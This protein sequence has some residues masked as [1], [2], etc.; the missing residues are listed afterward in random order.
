MMMMMMKKKKR[1]GRQVYW[2]ALWMSCLQ[3]KSGAVAH[4]VRVWL[5]TCLTTQPAALLAEQRQAASG[6]IL[7]NGVEERKGTKRRIDI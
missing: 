2:H 4:L 5:V 3:D 7:A 1:E 6:G